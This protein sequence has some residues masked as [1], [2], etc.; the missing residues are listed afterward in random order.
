[1]PVTKKPE[2]QVPLAEKIAVVTGAT[3]GIGLAIA[4]ELVAAGVRVFGLGRDRR[5]LASLQKVVRDGGEAL[6][7]D[8]SDEQA[9]TSTF[10]R[11]A[12][13]TKK[14]DFLIN[15]A[16][17]AHKTQN[18]D[19][20]TSE[21]W[22]RVLTTNLNGLFFVT[23]AA[24]S[25][26]RK[27]GVI[28][29][30]ISV[31]AYEPFAGFAAYNASKAGALAFTN[32]LREELRPR[33]IRV[34]ALVPGATDTGIWNQFWADAPREKMVAPETIAKLVVHILQAPPVASIDRID[35]L[36]AAGNL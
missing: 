8:V 1:M 34:T 3:R 29:N 24:L 26:M 28:V 22:H 17:V 21:N 6:A 33:G 25:M 19:R 15:N 10:S 27:G 32:S 23:R 20:M 4:Q 9:V 18:V 30:N 7:C 31:S 13:Q 36:S 12:S 2:L 11:I 35:V 16:G 5:A 14:I